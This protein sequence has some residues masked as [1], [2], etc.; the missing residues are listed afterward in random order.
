MTQLSIPVQQC[1]PE[2]LVF[3][4]D[5]LITLIH[6]CLYLFDLWSK[7]GLTKHLLIVL[8]RIAHKL[9]QVIN[10][11]LRRPVTQ[12]K[13]LQRSKV[14]E[15]SEL[16]ECDGDDVARGVKRFQELDTRIFKDISV[17]DVEK[18]KLHVPPVVVAISSCGRP[19]PHEVVRLLVPAN[20]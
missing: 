17:L 4:V 15:Q 10:Y 7:V 2:E 13:V 19:P 12:F 3:P 14:D 1:R 18:R 20:A 9:I 6:L 16:D 5:K 8:H 11:L